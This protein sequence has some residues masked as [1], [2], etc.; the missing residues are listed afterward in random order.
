SAVYLYVFYCHIYSSIS[1]V[2]ITKFHKANRGG[3]LIHEKFKFD[4]REGH[5]QG[6][7][8]CPLP[9]PMENSLNHTL[10]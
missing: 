10:E 1:R 7:K 2:F 5:F 6:W 8:Y 4:P 9:L 3:R